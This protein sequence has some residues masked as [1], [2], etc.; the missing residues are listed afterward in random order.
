MRVQAGLRSARASSN[1]RVLEWPRAQRSEASRFGSSLLRSA[2]AAAIAAVI[3]G[4]SWGVYWRVQSIQ[5]ARA[6]T[7]PLH[8]S[9]QRGFSSAGAMRTP[10]TLSGPMV[11][12]PAVTLPVTAA[13]LTATS[14]VQ[15]E[16]QPKRTA[17]N[18]AKTAASKA[19]VVPAAPPEK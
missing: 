17:V 19:I 5:P 1:G 8:L 9:T 13:P 18:P 3:V 7:V 10:Q 15:P 6:I 2:A 12:H 11:E 14:A 4:G 16:A